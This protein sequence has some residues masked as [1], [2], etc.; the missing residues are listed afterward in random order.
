MMNVT[1]KEM[2]GTSFSFGSLTNST[3]WKNFQCI[4]E[5]QAGRQTIKGI[6]TNTSTED[7]IETCMSYPFLTE[8]ENY[9]KASRIINM[10]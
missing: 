6:L 7:L 9:T 1:T 10:K 2:V 4:E 8:L 5:M 3:V